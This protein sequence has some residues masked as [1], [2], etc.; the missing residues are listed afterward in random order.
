MQKALIPVLADALK[1]IPIPP[2]R[3]SNSKMDLEVADLVLCGYDIIPENITL[4]MESE[5]HF[6]IQDLETVN[7]RTKLVLTLQNI[8]SQ[9][10]DVWFYFKRKTFPAIHDEGRVTISLTG[11]GAT[12]NASFLIIQGDNDTA[13]VF[14]SADVDF[15]IDGLHIDWDKTTI[16]HDVLL[17][18]A[19]TLFKAQVVRMIER[20]VEDKLKAVMT[21]VGRQLSESISP[22]FSSAM[23]KVRNSLVTADTHK[24]IRSRHEML[25]Q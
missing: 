1:Y 7:S 8:R 10:K 4:K 9:V 3:V 21:I 22:R 24:V 18:M 17:P 15:D 25:K 19:T 14:K 6:H 2:I 13:P 20:A 12:L 11:R 5:S 23:D 16:H